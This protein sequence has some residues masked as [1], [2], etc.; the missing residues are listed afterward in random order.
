MLFFCWSV[1]VN[2]VL[3]TYKG[4]P[5]FLSD[6]QFVDKYTASLSQSFG[7]IK[8]SPEFLQQRL[9]EKVF[10]EK[11]LQKTISEDFLEQQIVYRAK[12]LNLTRNQFEQ[13]IVSSGINLKDFKKILQYQYYYNMFLSYF[14]DKVIPVDNIN[15]STNYYSFQF[16]RFEVSKDEISE[17]NFL[18][19][20]KALV[21]EGKT[22][23]EKTF[24]A[25]Q[26]PEL[27]MESQLDSYLRSLLKNTKENSF[28]AVIKDAEKLV[29]FF[30]QKKIQKKYS[31][32][33]LQEKK[34]F[35][36]LEAI[37]SS[38]RKKEMSYIKRL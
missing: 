3:F 20:L 7:V 14:K 21:F 9:I 4:E 13:A 36:T 30:L 33:E 8:N 16:T 11:N 37:A 2:K 18:E 22:L 12:S 29:V 17:K 38:Y 34:S 25:S 32:Q 23:L 10:V 28:T 19:K 1:L 5:L 24:V 15:N 27:I 35:E 31:L 26:T 6:L